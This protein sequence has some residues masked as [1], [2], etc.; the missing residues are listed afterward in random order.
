MTTATTIGGLLPLMLT[1]SM[2]DTMA[3]AIVFG[4]ALATV[5]TLGFIPLLYSFFYRINFAEF[6]YKKAVSEGQAIY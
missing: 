6:D 1:G 3:I 4:L 2:F 5:L